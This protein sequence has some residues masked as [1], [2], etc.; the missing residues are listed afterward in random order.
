M[1]YDPYPW[2]EGKYKLAKLRNPLLDQEIDGALAAHSAGM[3]R[4]RGAVQYP[5]ETERLA[6]ALSHFALA[7]AFVTEELEEQSFKAF[8]QELTFFRGE[9]EVISLGCGPGSDIVGALHALKA[10]PRR[11]NLRA[12]D[13]EAAWR[14]WVED[15]V[16]EKVAADPLLAASRPALSFDT[17]ELGD[18]VATRRYL[19]PLQEKGPS[20]II[21][22]RVLGAIPKTEDFAS[23]LV[24]LA[25]VHAMLL[26]IEAPPG[27]ALLEVVQSLLERSPRRG[28]VLGAP[29][30][31]RGI[32]NHLLDFGPVLQQL[33]QKLAHH[34]ERRAPYT[35]LHYLMDTASTLRSS[36]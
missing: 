22:N 6:Y 35:A 33:D 13:R 34:L 30:R 18:P 16:R 4:N 7:A 25:S 21:M 29:N 36:A 12:V 32:Q 3:S 31:P 26:V 11:L 2:L 24:E 27:Q 23:L 1:Y 10:I 15:A 5:G 17:C 8:P 14:P 19:A 9:L 20:L 28:T